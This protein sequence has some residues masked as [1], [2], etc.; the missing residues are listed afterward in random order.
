MSTLN[1]IAISITKHAHNNK[2]VYPT[3]WP[4]DQST[5]DQ[6]CKDMA[7][8]ETDRGYH[9]LRSWGPDFVMVRGVKVV[10]G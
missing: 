6:L 1:V 10:V 3:Y 4:I 2:G 9:E 7:Q 5:F 8:Y